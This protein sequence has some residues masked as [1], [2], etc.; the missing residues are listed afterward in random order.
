MSLLS[1]VIID[2]GL[3]EARFLTTCKWNLKSN[4]L[5]RPSCSLGTYG[6]L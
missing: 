5:A 1:R 3:L 2:L 6:A 4:A